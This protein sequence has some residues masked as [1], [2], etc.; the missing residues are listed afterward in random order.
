MVSAHAVLCHMF[1]CVNVDGAPRAVA[2]EMQDAC[3]SDEWAGDG[4]WL[5]GGEAHHADWSAGNPRDDSDW[6]PD[7]MG[8]DSWG[9]E[10]TGQ[11]YHA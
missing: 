9:A 2:D 1:I 4:D 11:M 8:D 7:W 5:E 3:N 10:V 6:G